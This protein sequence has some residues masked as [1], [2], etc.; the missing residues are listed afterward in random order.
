MPP[1][2]SPGRSRVR[3]DLLTSIGVGLLVTI[4]ISIGA[5]IVIGQ[6]AEQQALSED[7][8]ITQRL[9]EMVMAEPLDAVLSGDAE[10][11]SDL[12]RLVQ[13]RLRDGTISRIDVWTIDGLIV[14]SD[15]GTKVGRYFPVPE[16]AV[17]AIERGITSSGVEPT[18]ETGS[19]PQPVQVDVY[20][21]MHLPGGPALAFE[22][23][24]SYHTVERHTAALTAQLVL[25]VIGALALLQ[26]VQIPVAVSLARRVRRHE[27]D[28]ARLL[29]QALSA[30]EQE[31]EE[32][33]SALH[34][35]V[36]Q[37]LA[38]IGFA[39]GALSLSEPPERRDITDRLAGAVRDAAEAL[40]KLVVSIYPPDL[41][42][43]GLVAAV[44]D[45]VK[46]M[47]DAGIV[48]RV[49]TEPLPPLDPDVA[50]TLYRT[51]REALTNVTK[52]A[53]AGAVD[54]QLTPDR[55]ARWEGGDAVLLRVSDDGVGPPEHALER[56]TDGHLGLT[57][58]ADRLA[59]IGGELTVVPGQRC[60]T[61]AEA[62][63]PARVPAA[64]PAPGRPSRRRSPHTVT[65]SG[66]AAPGAGP[67]VRTSA[68]PAAAPADPSA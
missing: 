55:D 5:L 63:M 8:R 64:V 48:A 11:H 29:E 51:A 26:L 56:R 53:Q 10:Q 46:P 3:R 52:H 66:R 32:I 14:Y 65:R 58:A 39:L 33:A 60:G 43:A 20:V 45:L 25:P 2:G 40:R 27:A 44:S 24:F 47:R 6:V 22:A 42:G 23:Y 16:E 31:R 38:G 41:S 9:A 7:E 17:A 37:D 18:P 54:V 49:E 30:S 28:R 50:A 1:R 19:T 12:D 68:A 4:V 61:V 21:P 13:A 34:D 15:D 36:V 57:M 62:R 59:A 35:G 67:S